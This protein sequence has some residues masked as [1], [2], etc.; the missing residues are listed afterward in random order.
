MVEVGSIISINHSH[1]SRYA[2]KTGQNIA[3]IK[4]ESFE[5]NPIEDNTSAIRTRLI[6]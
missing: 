4:K 2:R 6:A 5:L 1:W 3:L